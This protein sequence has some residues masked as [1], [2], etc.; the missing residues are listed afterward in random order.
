MALLPQRASTDKGKVALGAFSS[1]FLSFFFVERKEAGKVKM[2]ESSFVLFISRLDFGGSGDLFGESKVGRAPVLSSWREKIY[3]NLLSSPRRRRPPPFPIPNTKYPSPPTHNFIRARI[4]KQRKF[5]PIAKV[6]HLNFRASRTQGLRR[7]Q[8]PSQNIVERIME[9]MQVEPPGS[10]LIKK[11]Q[12][13][14]PK[15]PS[16]T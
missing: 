2:E 10:L 9:F 12:I 16:L 8:T 14:T 13:P 1:H 15:P 7:P 5:D 11:K 3:G 6:P 4:K